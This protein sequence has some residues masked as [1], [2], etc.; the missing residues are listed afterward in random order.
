MIQHYSDPGPSKL[1]ERDPQGAPQMFGGGPPYTN[2]DHQPP[3]TLPT[4][5]R[6]D[7]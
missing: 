7:P 5:V 3:A 4:K 6:L 1:A 2:Q